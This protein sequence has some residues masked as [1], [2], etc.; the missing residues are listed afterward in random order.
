MTN[1]GHS[2][3]PIGAGV[4]A[5]SK[6]VET[7]RYFLFLVVNAAW[8]VLRY[9]LHLR[10]MHSGLI[11][12]VLVLGILFGNVATYAG[13][14]LARKILA[15]QTETLWRVFCGFVLHWNQR[16]REAEAPAAQ[17]AGS[18]QKPQSAPGA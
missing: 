1:S 2:G 4:V 10:G 9:L 17:T 18:L 6:R 12:I 13:I 3:N 8:G 5:K 7:G 14:K 11:A 15:L 16:C